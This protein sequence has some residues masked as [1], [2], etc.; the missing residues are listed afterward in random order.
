EKIG[1]QSG[2]VFQ[3]IKKIFFEILQ[4]TLITYFQFRNALFIV[5]LKYS[6][7]VRVFARWYCQVMQEIHNKMDNDL[8]P[9]LEKFFA[10]TDFDFH[11]PSMKMP[12]LLNT[13]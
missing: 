4:P 5:L 7:R 2:T 13:D 8:S 9:I 1:I 11:Q 6:P 3:R 12:L 10:G